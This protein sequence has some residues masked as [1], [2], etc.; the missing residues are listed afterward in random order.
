MSITARSLQFAIRVLTIAPQELVRGRSETAPNTL[1]SAST[2]LHALS[3]TE[4][5][6]KAPPVRGSGKTD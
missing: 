1:S 5:H 2:R 6:V 3:E 4:P